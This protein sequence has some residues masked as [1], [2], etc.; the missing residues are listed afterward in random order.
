M[1]PPNATVIPTIRN[2]GKQPSGIKSGKI[3]FPNNA[4]VRPHIIDRDVVVVLENK[5]KHHIVEIEL[6]IKSVCI[7]LIDVGNKFTTIPSNAVVPILPEQV[8]KADNIT[9]IFESFA[10]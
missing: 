6:L 9:V 10:Q 4:P 2:G 5:T 8:Y 7:H 1:T 3:K